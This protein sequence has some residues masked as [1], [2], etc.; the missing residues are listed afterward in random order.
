MLVPSRDL[1]IIL[2]VLLIFA[3]CKKDVSLPLSPEEVMVVPEHFPKLNYTFGNFPPDEKKIALGRRLFYDPILSAN[4]TVS[5]SSCHNQLGAFSDEGKSVSSGIDGKL[6]FRNAPALFNLAWKP[7]F[8]WDGGI[9]NLELQPLAPITDAHEMANTFNEVLFRLNNDSFYKSSFQKA[10]NED[11]I[12]SQMVLVSFAQFLA[13]MVSYQSKYDQFYTGNYSALS[14]SEIEG[15]KIF[16]AKCS[17]CHQEPLMT[18]FS[19]RRNGLNP[20]TVDS[21]RQRITLHPDDRDK[22]GVP[23]LRNITLSAPYMHDGRFESLEEVILNY[24]NPENS[25]D[26][27]IAIGNGIDISDEEQLNLI[28]FLESLEDSQFITDTTFSNPFN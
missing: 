22:Y 18:D 11:E 3:S 20:T 5:C 4:N 25:S 12:S 8:M 17:A 28:D 6:G 10:F 9:V 14:A 23:S 24:R 2:G 19:F 27:D 15:L 16:R 13:T 7:L 26:I 1:S 21:G